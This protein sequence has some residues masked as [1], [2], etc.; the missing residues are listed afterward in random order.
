M[1]GHLPFFITDIRELTS[2]I[3]LYSLQSFRGQNLIY[4]GISHAL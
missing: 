1:A 2:Y 3:L 4:L